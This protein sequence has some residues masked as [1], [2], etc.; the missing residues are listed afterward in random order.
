MFAF[1]FVNSAVLGIK[2][3]MPKDATSSSTFKLWLAKMSRFSE[4]LRACPGGRCTVHGKETFV[5]EKGVCH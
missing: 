4:T 2:I 3:S 1:V 5:G